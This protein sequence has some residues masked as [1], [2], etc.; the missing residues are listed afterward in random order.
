MNR[1]ESAG[2]G[3][4]TTPD[5]LGE[6]GVTTLGVVIPVHNGEHRLGPT[7]TALAGQVPLAPRTRAH[8]VV[9]VNGS[10]DRSAATAQ[11]HAGK[12]ASSAADL[13][14]TVL[15]TRPGR[16]NAFNEAERLLPPGPRLYLDQD[17]ILAD[18]ALAALAAALT[19][20][21]PHADFAVPQLRLPALHSIAARAYYRT[22]LRLPYTRIAPIS[23]GAYAV[24]AAGRERWSQF[25]AL[26]SDDKYVRL[27]FDPPERTLLTETWYT[28]SLPD[29]AREIVQARRRYSR[30]NRELADRFPSLAIDE[31]IRHD[32]LWREIALHPARWPDAAVYAALYGTGHYLARRENR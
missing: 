10:T 9:A 19:G 23:V 31:G 14:Y 1:W 32:R 28:V 3:L 29:S 30:G 6:A 25:P 8:I 26:H 5:G 24:S 22:F 18:N 27:Q 15:E 16:A 17:A 7:L 20:K 4:R 21:G 11:R 12:I 13:D 2:D